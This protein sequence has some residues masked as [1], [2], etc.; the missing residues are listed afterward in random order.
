MIEVTASSLDNVYA[1]LSLS[2]SSSSDDSCI[3]VLA[4]ADDA[5]LL[6]EPSERKFNN[7]ENKSSDIDNLSYKA[8]FALIAS[9]LAVV[10]VAFLRSAG[11]QHGH[12][13]GIGDVTSLAQVQHEADAN[14]TYKIEDAVHDV[15]DPN[16]PPYIAENDNMEIQFHE[17]ER[18]MTHN[19]TLLALPADEDVDEEE[20][21][22]YAAVRVFDDG[23]T[24][25]VSVAQWIN[26]MATPY[27]ETLSKT[28]TD[29]MLVSEI[30]PEAAFA[31]HICLTV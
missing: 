10:S 1:G 30:A 11:P 6:R 20:Y 12:S 19:T 3:S 16:L 18:G 23:H 25:P 27:Y 5:P 7:N 24:E 8:T 9:A 26:L 17:V 22:R 14:A 4:D 29:T 2:S 21:V 13:F 15:F 31:N 28:L